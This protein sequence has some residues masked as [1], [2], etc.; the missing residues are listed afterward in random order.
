MDLI[1][2][3][4]VSDFNLKKYQINKNQINKDLS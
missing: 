3:G 4:I 2:K 1:N